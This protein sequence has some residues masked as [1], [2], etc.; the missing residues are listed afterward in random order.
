MKIN[1]VEP[2]VLY[3][4]DAT[5]GFSDKPNVGGYTG[6][7]VIVRVETDDGFV[8]WGECCTG[9]DYGEAAFAVKLLIGRRLPNHRT[10][11]GRL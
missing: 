10:E 6:Y 4:Q 7:Q 9:S 3:A 5:A 1:S 2:I 8:G 11:P